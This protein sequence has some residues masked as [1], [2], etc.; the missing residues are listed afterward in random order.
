MT[1]AHDLSGLNLPLR[2]SGF[3]SVALVAPPK[4]CGLRRRGELPLFP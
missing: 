1:G 4:G 2:H 3:L